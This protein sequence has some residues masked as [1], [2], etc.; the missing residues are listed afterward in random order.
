MANK[1]YASNSDVLRGF[2]KCHPDI[3]PAQPSTVHKCSKRCRL[4]EYKKTLAFVCVEHRNIHRCGDSCTYREE[5]GADEVCALT[6]LVLRPA[7][8]V[9]QPIFSKSDRIVKQSHQFRK[10]GPSSDMLKM[11]R[12]SGWIDTALKNLLCSTQRSMLVKAHKLRALKATMR[13]LKT[14]GTFVAAQAAAALV[15]IRGGATL[16]PAANKSDIELKILHKQ[17]CR[18]VMRFD[19]LKPTQ[20][21]ITAFVAACIHRLSTGMTIAGITV[22]FKSPYVAKHAPAEMA[23]SELCGVPCRQVSAMHRLIVTKTVGVSG[24]PD[25]KYIF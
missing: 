7:P 15:C 18:Y 13:A 24:I 20:R 12:I 11:Q 17:L 22:F 25:Q 9:Y 2:H 14:R 23:H 4:W 21:Q 16:Q 19:G 3:A 8:L 10:P 6:G 5:T 1:E